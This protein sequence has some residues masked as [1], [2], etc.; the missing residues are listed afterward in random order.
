[1]RKA[2]SRILLVATA[3]AG[4]AF[5]ALSLPAK[6]SLDRSF[7]PSVIAMPSLKQ[8][9]MVR[10]TYHADIDLYLLEYRDPQVQRKLAILDSDLR[11]SFWKPLGPGQGFEQRYIHENQDL[12]GFSAT[13]DGVAIFFS[14]R[15]NSLKNALKLWRDFHVP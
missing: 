8:S 1:M 5:L 7:D 15:S 13:E 14:R 9:Q 6:L 11:K 10:G 3:I 12:I 2:L 4:L